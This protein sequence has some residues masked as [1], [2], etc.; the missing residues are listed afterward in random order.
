MRDFLAVP[1]VMPSA[2]PAS[3]RA[4]APLQIIP[5]YL[6]SVAR[7]RDDADRRGRRLSGFEKDFGS[8]GTEMLVTEINWGRLT[9]STGTPAP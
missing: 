2:S 6:G 9:H 1:A 8:A 5:R 4:P 3:L 7:R